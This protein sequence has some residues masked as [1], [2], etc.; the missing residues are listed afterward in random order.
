MCAGMICGEEPRNASVDV[1]VLSG[2]RQSST[3][4]A[5]PRAP[6]TWARG[7]GQASPRPATPWPR[8]H[9]CGCKAQVAL[10]HLSPAL[11]LPLPL[12]LALAS[13]A[14]SSALEPED[15]TFAR[16]ILNLSV[17]PAVVPQ[18]PRWPRT[19]LL[20]T[21]ACRTLDGRSAPTDDC[22]FTYFHRAKRLGKWNS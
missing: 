16:G 18:S 10:I 22:A 11:P 8:A 15:A 12:A 21:P 1:T 20:H 2:T 19:R 17:L 14:S 5:G 7:R 9:D 6:T 4:M 3:A 13:G